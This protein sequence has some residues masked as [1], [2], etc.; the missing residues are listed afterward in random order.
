MSEVEALRSRVAALEAERES[1]RS[2]SALMEGI[3][4]D[5]PVIAYRV[6]ENGI[7]TESVG[8]GLERLGLRD[9]E[10]LGVDVFEVYPHTSDK[11]RAALNGAT[12]H[13]TAM[14]Q[15]G[16][17]TYALDSYIAF[18]AIRGKGAVGFVIDVTE[19]HEAE[20]AVRE[21]D[22][23]YR[24]LVELSPDAIAV[25][26]NGTFL[27]VSRPFATLFG[28]DSAEDMIGLD[29]LKLIPEDRQS[30][31]RSNIRRVQTD[32]V[33]HHGSELRALTLDGREII[34]DVTV[35][36]IQWEGEQAL[37]VV[38]RDVTEQQRAKNALSER[39]RV[40]RQAIRAS[41]GVAY[42]LIFGT[43]PEK[44]HFEFVDDAI[45]DLLGLSPKEFT[46]QRMSEIMI[47]AVASK[48]ATGMDVQ[49]MDWAYRQGILEAWHTDLHLRRPDGKECWL[50][51]D[52]V[53]VRDGKTRKVI[54][55]MGILHDITDRKQAES[56]V[57]R[58]E[59]IYRR[60]I[61]CAEGVAYEIRFEE[62]EIT[63]PYVYIDEGAQDLVGLS[64]EEF[65]KRGISYLTEKVVISDSIWKGSIETLAP[66]FLRGEVKSYHADLH[67]RTPNG[68]EKWLSDHAVPVRDDKTGRVIGSLG[69][70]QNITAR[71]RAEQEARELQ[72]QL[73]QAQKMESIGL[74]AGGIAHD[75]NNLL[76]A[77]Q[78]YTD[79]IL[80]EL[81][82][83]GE[84]VE[85]LR[86]IRRSTENGAELVKQL[87]A[88]S[89][90]QRIDPTELELN[91][92][93][94]ETVDMVSRLMPMN[95]KIVPRLGEGLHA[96]RADRGQL[97]LVLV[98]LFI[99][100]RD[101]M[102]LGGQIRVETENLHRT[103]GSAGKLSP[104]GEG[105]HV[106]VRLIDNGE[107]MSREVRER[108]FEPFFTTKEPGQ[109]T[110]LG[111]AMVYGIIQQHG[112]T[113]E[114]QSEPGEG[115]TMEIILPANGTANCS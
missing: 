108:I 93:V 76:L 46:G 3:L 1:L 30:E 10:S 105:P 53:P 95:V 92:L 12:V 58:R 68:E 31:V 22:E 45:E 55:S 24:R 51:D 96:V 13:F 110:G 41:E 106:C 36:E 113:I 69:I 21:S 80:K 77:V 11:M 88:F 99:N 71:V 86:A 43:P 6:D 63:G 112:G 85:C 84:T 83:E 38:V 60:A 50:S 107:G 56:G 72:A 28:A 115:T 82:P 70:L 97:E 35:A 42:R 111:L 4:Q 20:Q 47:E 2:K 26:R 103:G 79:Y 48:S 90:R 102:P 73:L 100:A 44:P 39:E 81:K 34:V 101:A 75:F 19:R 54:G 25:H 14:G 74:L 89:R 62:G 57:R 67:L 64:P 59:E 17:K 33:P 5:L 9:H 27:S 29:V 109:G 16:G 8:K 94:H 65:S 18:D 91:Q 7:V 23:R 32:K 98:N 40:Y 15:H 104:L 114:V 87:L 37:Q 49:Q 66:A 61:S 52:A 78:G